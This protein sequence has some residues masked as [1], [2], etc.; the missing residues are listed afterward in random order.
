MK[1]NCILF[2][3]DGRRVTDTVIKESVFCLASDN[4]FPAS[5]LASGVVCGDQLD[6]TYIVNDAKESA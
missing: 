1:I 6:V 5:H 4:P 3:R 2:G